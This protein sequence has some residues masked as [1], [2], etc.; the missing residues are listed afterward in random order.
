MRIASA[1]WFVIVAAL[2]FVAGLTFYIGQRAVIQALASVDL[3]LRPFVSE[4]TDYVVKDGKEVVTAKMTVARTSSGATIKTGTAYL[5]DG[6]AI[7]GVRRID[8]PDGFVAMVFDS[9]KAKST[10]RKPAVTLAQTKDAVLNTPPNCVYNGEQ[11]DG[12]D[13]LQGQRTLRITRTQQDGLGRSVVWKLPDYNCEIVQMVIQKKL[14]GGPSDSWETTAGSHLTMFHDSEPDNALLSG[15]AE[16]E[17]MKPSEATRRLAQSMGLSE[18]KACPTCKPG[19]PDAEYE[20][21]HQQ[22]AGK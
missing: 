3:N 15:F 10:G 18:P 19:S 12:E 21:W 2:V 20:K 9:L 8:L 22:A 6:K 7:T 14:V 16:Y 5:P 13:Y 17:E 11:L 4:Q 1:R